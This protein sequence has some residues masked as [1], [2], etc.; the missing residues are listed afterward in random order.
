MHTI[1][2]LPATVNRMLFTFQD[3]S[4]F[5]D[6][7]GARSIAPQNFHLKGV[8]KSSVF[9]M[10]RI[11]QRFHFVIPGSLTVAAHHMIYCT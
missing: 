5:T 2:L 7:I 3:F 8:D 11:L 10:L 4:K 9:R 6:L 1:S